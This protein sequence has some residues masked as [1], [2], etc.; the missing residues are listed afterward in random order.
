MR[1]SQ[2]QY[3]LEIKKYGSITRAA[4]HLF[5]TQP[6]MSAAMKELE[7]E[8]GYELIKRSKKGV[9]FTRLGEQVAE[10]AAIIIGEMEAI[11]C[12]NQASDSNMSGRILVAATPFICEHFMLDL[13]VRLKDQYPE[14]Y[15][16]L[17]EIDASTIFQQVNQRATDIGLVMICNNEAERYR[18]ELEKNNLAFEEL[19]EDEMYFFV[20]KQN[21]YYGAEEA[22]LTEI[23]RYP[24]V[25]Y[26]NSYTDEDRIFFG[27]YCDLNLLKTV[28]MK[29]KESVKKYVMRSQ[30]VTAMPCNASKENIY[31]QTGLLKPLRIADVSWT[32]RIGVVYRK[33]TP[34]VREE[35]FL[36]EQLQQL[37][38]ERFA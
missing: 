16:I 14:L 1:L 27:Q 11:R 28:Q 3:L 24:Y 13:I 7:E 15:L 10:K 23:L 38:A 5:I 6:S 35:V 29:D 21:P 26:K 32:C 34:L 30:S 31:L 36:L 2:L 22:S 8:L 17:D 4:Q 33:D 20:G 37:L 12:L 19:Y 9:T 18:R 25:Y